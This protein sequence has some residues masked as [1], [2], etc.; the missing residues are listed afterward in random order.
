[1]RVLGE[2]EV[3]RFSAVTPTQSMQN[4]LGCTIQVAESCTMLF[5]TLTRPKYVGVDSEVMSS[6]ST[7]PMHT[8]SVDPWRRSAP[9]LPVNQQVYMESLSSTLRKGEIKRRWKWDNLTAKCRGGVGELWLVGRV[10]SISFMLGE[11]ISINI[12]RKH[13]AL[14][15]I[16]N[17]QKQRCNKISEPLKLLGI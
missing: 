15:S 5:S 13:V 12:Y 9:S 14:M 17:E 10:L 7:L 4:T 8:T 16:E 6:S 1:M 11:C 2:G 3:R